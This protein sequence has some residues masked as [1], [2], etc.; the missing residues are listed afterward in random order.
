MF[1]G[2]GIFRDGVM[3]ALS[4]RRTIHLKTDEASRK[5]LAREGSI[6]FK[7]GDGARRVVTSYWRMPDHAYDDANIL[8]AYADTAYAAAT[9]LK[10][11]TKPH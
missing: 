1:G 2:L 9:H 4:M 11:T 7:H 5:T 10:R 3:F 8:K 6:A